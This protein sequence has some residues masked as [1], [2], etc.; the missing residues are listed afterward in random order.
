MDT[1]GTTVFILV[2][3]ICLNRKDINNL[4]SNSK[5][6]EVYKETH[7]FEDTRKNNKSVFGN[8]DFSN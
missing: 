8:S 3:H 4:V 5:E 6:L 1:A 7:R 2:L